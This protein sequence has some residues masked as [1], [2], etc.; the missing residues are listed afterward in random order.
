MSKIS[1]KG[2]SIS[3]YLHEKQFSLLEAI[4]EQQIK[5]DR[6]ERKANPPKEKKEKTWVVS[7]QMFQRGMKPEEIAKERGFTIGTI[8]GHLAKF[9]SSGDIL[10]SDILSPDHY[11]A[12]QK[13]ISLVG[14]DGG[15]T[16]IKDLCPPEVTYGE[17]NLVLLTMEASD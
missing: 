10:L 17:I 12:I 11:D 3:T 13:A 6:R 16:A 15:R 7:Y 1:Q 4:D 8:Y 14:K 2:F 5:K 9:V